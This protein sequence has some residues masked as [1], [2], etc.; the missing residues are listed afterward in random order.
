MIEIKNIKKTFGDKEILSDISFDAKNGSIYGLIGKNGAGKTTLLNILAGLSE[1]D[2]GTMVTDNESKKEKIA[3]LPDMPSFFDYMT[4]GEYIDFLIKGNNSKNSDKK[5]VLDLVNI[6]ENVF[7]KSMSRGMKQKFGIASILI[8][9]P[10][11]ILLDEPTSALDPSG[12]YDVMNILQQLKNEGKTIILSTH[13]LS[14]MEKICDKVGFLHAGK[15]VREVEIQE[16][17]SDSLELGIVFKD[18]IDLKIFQIPDCKIKKTENV[19]EIRSVKQS[20]GLDTQKILFRTLSMLNN[21]IDYIYTLK[22]ELETIFH[23][24]CE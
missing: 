10:D 2:A 8:S 11:I 19:I 12:R 14:D 24:V 3:F 16:H 22:P 21:Q 9:N 17:Y 1:A 4:A 5:R 15:I 13:I 18:D 7:L 6:S 23:E 20:G